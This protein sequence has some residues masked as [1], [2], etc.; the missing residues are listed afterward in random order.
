ML[1]LHPLASA[2]QTVASMLFR[3]KW[4]DCWEGRRGDACLRI[5][6]CVPSPHQGL[7]DAHHACVSVSFYS[8]CPCLVTR[9]WLRMMSTS[10]RK[11][12]GGGHQGTLHMFN[13]MSPSA[14]NLA[15]SLLYL[16]NSS[17]IKCR[18]CPVSFPLLIPI[19]I[20]KDDIVDVFCLYCIS[21]VPR[22]CCVLCVLN[23]VLGVCWP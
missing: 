16:H 15:T 10:Q 14:F 4:L 13:C 22:C 5:P 17:T 21:C 1:Q 12:G 8:W 20:L 11:V 7:G 18:L 2:L 23:T 19:P 6:A 3:F 9:L